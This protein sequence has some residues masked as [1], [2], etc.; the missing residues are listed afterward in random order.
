[1]IRRPPFDDQPDADI[2]SANLLISAAEF[3]TILSVSKRTLWRLLS[4]GKLPLAVHIGRS[5]RWRLDE[6]NAWIAAGCPEL[7]TWNTIAKDG[8]NH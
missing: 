8:S 6:I 3:A 5:P 4:A 2:R 7:H 1:M